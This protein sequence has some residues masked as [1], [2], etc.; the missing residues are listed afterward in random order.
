[1]A[2]RE[3]RMRTAGA[4]WC[5]DWCTQP[6][7]ENR[8]H[9]GEWDSYATDAGWTFWF[10]PVAA[11]IDQGMGGPGHV[12]LS[13]TGDTGVITVDDWRGI[14]GAYTTAEQQVSNWHIFGRQHGKEAFPGAYDEWA[15]DAEEAA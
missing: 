13:V 8:N 4:F 12:D 14:D 9:I 6:D 3:D 1:M 15:E 2:D 11:W 7:D 10:R 5:P